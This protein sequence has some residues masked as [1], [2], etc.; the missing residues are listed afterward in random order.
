MLKQTGSQNYRR[1]IN[2]T[3]LCFKCINEA[4]IGEIF[5]Q[6]FEFI[7]SLEFVQYIFFLVHNFFCSVHIFFLP[8]SVYSCSSLSS[9]QKAPS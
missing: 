8:S 9:I 2:K 4:I 1:Y 5:V 7:L 3:V 6:I